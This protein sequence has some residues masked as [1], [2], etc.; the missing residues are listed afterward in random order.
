MAGPAFAADVEVS[1]AW[2]RALPAK[3]PAAGYFT[4][5]NKGK[6]AVTLTGAETDACGM[7]MLHRSMQN[8]GTS[9]MQDVDSVVVPAGGTIE[10]AQGGYHL[11]C[12]DPTPAL[13]PGAKIAVTLVFA[14][15][16]KVT[17][18]F[19]VKNARGE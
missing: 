11:M 17:S 1:G 4:L 9:S 13:K 5:H 19:A 15:G 16:A 10:F 3:L 18:D 7:A 12:M 14:G 2:M 8:G 6:T